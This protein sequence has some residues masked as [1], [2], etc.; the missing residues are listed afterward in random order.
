[1][2]FS[3][4]LQIIKP[5][6][7][8]VSLEYILSI[9]FYEKIINYFSKHKKK[10][11][12]SY[13]IRWRKYYVTNGLPNKLSFKCYFMIELLLASSEFVRPNTNIRKC[14]LTNNV[15]FLNKLTTLLVFIYDYLALYLTRK[16][17]LH[18][19]TTMC[20]LVGDKAT[21]HKVSFT[22]AE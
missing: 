19:I 16:L 6:F 18:K 21:W 4:N 8:F 12:N 3:F 7:I 2:G 22:M 14:Q 5:I 17:F 11:I 1:M 13:K 9:L 15:C 20:N 10:S